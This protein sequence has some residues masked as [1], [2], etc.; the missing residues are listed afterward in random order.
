[1]ARG[2]NRKGKGI[3]KTITAQLK[4]AVALE[5]LK[6]EKTQAQIA[7]E[8]EVHPNQVSAWKQ[9][10]HAVLVESFAKKRGRKARENGAGEQALHEQIG[11]LQMELDWLK[12]NPNH[13]SDRENGHDRA[14]AGT[15]HPTPVHLLKVP[16]GRW[17]APTAVESAEDL[18][19]KRLLDEEYLRHP[20]YG[21]RRM[22]AYLRR[23]GRTINR[24]RVRGLLRE[25]GITAIGPKPNT[26]R[27]DKAHPVCPYLLREVV[28]ERVNQVWST[29]ISVLQQCGQEVQGRPD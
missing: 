19:L 11:R 20:F 13:T 3:R 14:T 1:M 17:Y 8:Y 27:R 5:A 6:G 29:D 2:K 25:M 15:L 28:I 24:K 4:A 22:T 18:E 12:K 23:L 9:E 10:A 7:S 26:S 16:R 21:S